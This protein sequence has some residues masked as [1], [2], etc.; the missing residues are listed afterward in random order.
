MKNLK[1][2]HIIFISAIIDPLLLVISFWVS[3]KIV[4]IEEFPQNSYF[5]FPLI[6]LT[7]IWFLICLSLNLY[8][9]SKHLF[10]HVV[11]SRNTVGLFIFSLASAG[12]IFL[13][14]DYK[15]SR[16]FLIYALLIH[17]IFILVWRSI[18]FLTEKQMRK[19]GY[20]SKK[21]MLVGGGQKIED[22]IEGI[23]NNPIYG[24]KLEAVFHCEVFDKK[25]VSKEV[26][27]GNLNEAV[28]YLKNNKIDQLLI[29]LDKED[30]ELTRDL[31]SIADNNLVRVHIIPE[32][33]NHFSRRFS[34]DYF[35]RLPVLKMREE[36]LILSTNRVL[37]RSLDVFCAFMTVILMFSWMFP[38][39]ALAIKLTSKGPLFFIQKRTGLEGKEFNCYKFRTMTVNVDS[40]NKQ[41]TKNDNRI[42]TVGKFLRKTSLDELPQIFNILQNHMSLVGPRPHMLKH[43]DKYKTLVDKF[44]VRHY[45]KPG[46]TGWAQIHGFRG[47]T[48]FIEDMEARAEA[49]IWY[50]ENWSLFLDMKIIYETI[51]MILFKKEINAY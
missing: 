25:L 32:F 1:K 30:I 34:I 21:A 13:T 7:I 36:P 10:T 11:L 3:R 37:K 51:T 16:S 22:I 9:N 20:F 24:L 28:A 8:D 12:F 29:A 46:I 2:E 40:D 4:F 26:T 31:L 39:I 41:A 17:G 49:D 27:K 23:Y 38:I 50:V 6:G 14:T 19:K 44:M 47:E 15:Y 5:V 45:A 33:S 43:T 35:D 48:K 18:I 42:T